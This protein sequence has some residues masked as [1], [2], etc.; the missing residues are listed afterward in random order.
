MKEV[1]IYD[2]FLKINLSQFLQSIPHIPIKF[3]AKQWL[4][5]GNLRIAKNEL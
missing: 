3:A 4:T 1:V 2:I 5:T